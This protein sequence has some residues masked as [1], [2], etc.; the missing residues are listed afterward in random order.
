MLT[1]PPTV[2]VH[3]AEGSNSHAFPC[4]H[5]HIPRDTIT[6]S[7]GAQSSRVFFTCRIASIAW[8]PPWAPSSSMSR[9]IPSSENTSTWL[10]DI[11]IAGCDFVEVEGY[12]SVVGASHS[13]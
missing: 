2:T 4:M 12:Q 13:C 1:L 3:D 11:D 10:D 7:S 8:P 5:R 9:T 6:P